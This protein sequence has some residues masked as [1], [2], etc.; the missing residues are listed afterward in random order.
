MAENKIYLDNAATSW[1]KP[2]SVYQAV[3]AAM[4]E[5]GA[6]PGRGSYR[7]SVAAQRLVDD[8]RL[9][10]C[11][12]FNAPDPERVI[13]TL[14]CTDALNT[15]LKGLVRP[16]H[17]VVMGPYEHNSVLRPLHSL[18]QAGAHVAAANPTAEFGVDL[19]HFRVLCGDHVDYAVISHVS[20]VT[21]CVAP[22]KEIAAIV[23]ERGGKLILDTA[24][25]AGSI[26][27]D[28]Q[29]MGVDVL[30]APGHKGL[31][32]PMGTGILVL[33]EPLAVTP[34]RE[35]GTGFR[36]ESAAQ[37]EEYPCRLEAGTI[38]LPGIAGLAAG[39]RFIRAAGVAATGAHEAMLARIAAEGLRQ[40]EGVRVFSAADGSCSG[41][42]S[43]VVDFLE[44]AVV[45]AILDASFG[46]AVRTGLH[47][48]PATHRILGTFPHGTLRA[49]FGIFNTPDHARA[50][51]AA[52]AEI[53]KQKT[54]A[55]ATSFLR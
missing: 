27:I 41:V 51:V 32:G 3:N 6:N 33:A 40:L 25:S 1:P 21:G 45:G 20:N 7:M 47:C 9:E 54:T 53:C 34:L 11:R 2:E 10:V 8:T 43:F 23:H 17:N 48:A 14:N 15:A 49:S 30:A 52:I 39:I 38:N 46:I 24:Q 19:E 26:E 44:P 16:G 4:R 29:E 55:S 5:H 50:L 37:P 13:F 31:L 12:L 22:V 18:Q 42:V 28:M 35:G 36:S